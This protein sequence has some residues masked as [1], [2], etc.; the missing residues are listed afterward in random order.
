MTRSRIGRF[1]LSSF[2]EDMSKPGTGVFGAAVLRAPPDLRQVIAVRIISFMLH[3]IT[4]CFGENA[5]EAVYSTGK[6]KNAVAG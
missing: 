5:T 1:L 3:G 4:S 2:F 6:M